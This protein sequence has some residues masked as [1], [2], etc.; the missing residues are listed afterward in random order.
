MSDYS[1]ESKVVYDKC[2]DRKRKRPEPSDGKGVTIEEFSVGVYRLQQKI[3]S[4][5]GRPRDLEVEYSS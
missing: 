2:R 1:S 4:A 3:G 5:G